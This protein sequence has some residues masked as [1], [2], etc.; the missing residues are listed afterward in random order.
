MSAAEPK[1][2]LSTMQLLEYFRFV[3]KLKTVKRTG[4]V[5]KNINNP[6]SVSDHMYR[7]SMIAMA[8]GGTNPARTAR[9]VKL[10]LVHDLAEAEVGDIAPA[11]NVSKEE[12]NAREEAAMRDIRDNVLSGSPLGVELYELWLEYETGDTEDAKLIKEIDK[13]EMIIQADE[14]E[15]AQQK[16]LDDFFVSTK[17]AFHTPVMCAIDHT[18]RSQRNERRGRQSQTEKK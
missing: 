11:D 6:E 5:Y 15:R 7:M 10:A 12:K 14:Y 13:M 9:L 8:V 4:W 1:N 16:E 3:G 17:D 18:L 2:C